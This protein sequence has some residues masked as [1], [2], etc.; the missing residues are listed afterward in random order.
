LESF[1][2]ICGEDWYLLGS[3]LSYLENLHSSIYGVP[4]FVEHNFFGSIKC[5]NLDNPW[6][7]KMLWNAII[8]TNPVFV[9]V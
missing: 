3:I 5:I 8:P 2:D 7:L 4:I 6:I 1:D 9:T